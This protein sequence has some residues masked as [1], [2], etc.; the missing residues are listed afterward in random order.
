MTQVEALILGGS[1]GVWGGISGTLTNQ[2]DL[3]DAL[4][5]KEDVGEAAALLAIHEAAGNPHAQY[6]TNA[7]ADALY[8]A[9]GTA[10]TL[11][12]AHTAASDPHPGYLTSA[13]G[14]AAFQ[15]LDSDLTTLAANIT[16]AGHALV[17]D[18]NAAAQRTTL[19]LGNVD[20]TSDAA[21]PV[22]TATQTA[23]NGKQDLDATLT[24]LAGLNATAG[25]VEQTGADAFT[26]RAF[27]VGAST[28]VPTRADA[29]ARYDAAG[30][31]A[32]AQAASQPLDA[33]LTALAGLNA[34]AGLV[35]ETGADAFTKRLI[36]VAN[37]TDIPT[38]AD[39]DARFSAL[40]HTHP[41]SD[42]TSLVSDLAGKQPLDATLTALAGL[43]ATAGLVEETG[44]DTFTKRLLGVAN[45]TDIPTRADADARFAALVHTH[46]ASQISDSTAA[47]RA[48]LTA[49]DA[50]AQTALL[51]IFTSALKGLVPLSG[52]GTANFLRADG[53]WQP[54]GA[55]A[56]TATQVTVNLPYPGSRRHVVNVID[57]AITA[58]DKIVV[59]LAG[60]AETQTNASDGIDP[61]GFS[62][63]AKAGSFDFLIAFDTPAAGPLV[64]NYARSA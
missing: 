15:P 62:A 43:N 22:S 16:A 61:L 18:A 63:L 2:L 57:A 29:D 38:R 11:L 53:T 3:V 23:L 27:G 58:T 28:S 64:I 48:M 25:I 31:A 59:S 17:D 32:A 37:S 36:G 12:A 35:E 19:G 7:E 4:N 41:E 45:S 13:E 1:A 34:T 8:E 21:K 46:T 55:S 50:A 47:G 39:A 42:I 51:N 20:N 40:S 10:S 9:L 26:K 56:F 5:N 54:P 60:V 30:A 44:A 52:G 14:T 49:A 24:A 33:T 6:L